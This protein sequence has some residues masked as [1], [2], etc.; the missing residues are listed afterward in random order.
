MTLAI[1]GTTLL[2]LT[3]ISLAIVAFCA[4]IIAF[5]LLSRT[6]P[7]AQGVIAS[8]TLHSGENGHHIKG[9][10]VTA[11]YSYSVGHERLGKWIAFG[12]PGTKSFTTLSRETAERLHE[13][14]EPGMPIS[15]Y[16]WPRRPSFS[17]LF[18]GVYWQVLL[19]LILLPV[20]SFLPI[21]LA[22]LFWGPN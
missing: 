12:R 8:S 6:W 18:P 16:Y 10:W 22:W 1:F 2:I 20:F 17:V 4:F 21:W 11:E 3:L 19:W 9:Y 14:L 5:G 15:V 13:Q 7:S